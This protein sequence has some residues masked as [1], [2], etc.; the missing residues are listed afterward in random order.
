MQAWRYGPKV[1]GIELIKLNLRLKPEIVPEGIP[2]TKWMSLQRRL[3]VS[4]VLAKTLLYQDGRTNGGPRENIEV[5]C[6][7]DPVA[8]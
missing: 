4:T 3:R 5:E 6:G 2:K 1:G 7:F 8:R